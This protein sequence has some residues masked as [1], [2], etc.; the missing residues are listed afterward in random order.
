MLCIFLRG[1]ET[2]KRY[3]L[4]A[5]HSCRSIS[6]CG[7][8]ASCVKIRLCPCNKERASLMQCIQS[9]EIDVAAIHNVER[10]RLRYKN[11]EHVDVV[12][13]S[14]ANVNETRNGTAQSPAGYAFSP[15][16]WSNGSWPMEIPRDTDRSLWSPERRPCPRAP[17]QAARQHT[18]SALCESGP[19]RNQPRYAS[20]AIHWHQPAWSAPLLFAIP[21]GTA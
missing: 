3:S 13:F 19:A 6:L 5:Y 18:S 9:R 14:I 11:I 21:Y 7:I 16:P 17:V 12:K 10:A 15:R 1:V 2:G 4:V 8:H 20:L